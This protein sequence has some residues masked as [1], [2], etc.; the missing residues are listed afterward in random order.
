ML[1]GVPYAGIW[2]LLIFVLGVLQIPL[3]IVTLPIIIYIFAHHD[4]TTAIIWTILF[5]IAGFSDNILRPILLGQGAPVP[6]VVIFIGVIGGF[7][8]TGFIGLFTGAIVFSIGY[9]LFIGWINSGVSP[10]S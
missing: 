2:T 5:L 6:M 4:T 3:F 10:T 9:K 1:A 8:F 7:M